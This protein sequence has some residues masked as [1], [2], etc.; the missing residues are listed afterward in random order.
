MIEL[1]NAKKADP[2]NLPVN[3]ALSIKRYDIAC[4]LVSAFE[5]G[6]NYWCERQPFKFTKP[7]E[8]RPV[9]DEDQEKPERWPMY[10]YPLL[11]GGAIEF[12]ADPGD[13]KKKKYRLDLDTIQKGLQKM[14]EIAPRHFGD[15]IN[16]NADAV[17][18]D[19]FVQICIFGEIVYG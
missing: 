3:V 10:D 4:L 9:L 12:K 5:G 11:E 15:F 17:T 7:T 16:D 14:A 19:V 2:K 13:G 18:G 8:W 6:I 1:A